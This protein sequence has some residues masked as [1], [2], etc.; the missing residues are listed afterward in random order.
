M[1]KET[2]AKIAHL[3]RLEVDPKNEEQLLHD[4]SE[5][6]TWVEKLNEVDTEGVQPLTHM[7]KEINLLRE[8]HAENGLDRNDALKLSPKNNDGFFTVPKV[9]KSKGK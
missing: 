2:L 1:T 3:S 4:L 9:I 6:I 8:D 7:S 5:I